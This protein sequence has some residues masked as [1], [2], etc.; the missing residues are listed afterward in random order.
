MQ[1]HRSAP[2]EARPASS[3]PAPFTAALAR[4]T[5]LGDDRRAWLLGWCLAGLAWLLIVGAAE[6]FGRFIGSGQ[7]ARSYWSATL[8][9]PYANSSWTTP[10]AYVYSP[11]F[12][13]LVEPLARLPWREF[14]AAWTGILIFAVAWLCGR[15][16]LALGIVVA[17]MELA[18]GNIS[19][20]MAVA[21]VLGFRWPSLWSFVLLTK[22]TPGIGLLWF[23][24]RREW[25]HLALA[26]LTT[27]GIVLVSGVAMPG[28]WTTWL[29]VLARN[30]GRDG[31]WASVPVPLVVRLPIAVVLVAWGARSN[32][33]WVV[34]VAAMLALPALW[35]GSLSMLLALIPLR[36]GLPAAMPRVPP[37]LVPQA[38]ARLR[39]SRA[40]RR[41]LAAD[42]R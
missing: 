11:A 37:D 10:G 6:P 21:I 30:V 16:F 4:W 33:P 13:Q 27:I 9:A 7:D 15:Q 35:Y 41:A 1:A 34:P 2:R 3:L 17:G 25:R 39:N 29:E 36:H 12:L 38:I 19:L 24:V 8:A 23:A 14:M 26:L 42:G 32:R 31:T 22:V 28:A 40:Y 18:G 5:S 20:L